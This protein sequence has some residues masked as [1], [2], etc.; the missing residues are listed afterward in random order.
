MPNHVHLILIINKKDE[1]SASPTVP[2]M[3]R[4][5]KSR[6]TN[7]YLEYIK[8]NQLNISGE[9]WQRSFYDHIIRN[10]KSLN[11]IR[12]YIIDNP[13]NWSEDENN[14]IKIHKRREFKGYIFSIFFLQ[15]PQI[16]KIFFGCS[17]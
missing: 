8:E 4:S 5:L 14:P 6:C 9:I 15:C 3:I 13:R 17:L 12:Q 7:Q 10:E 16:T 2:Q 1:A 11:Q